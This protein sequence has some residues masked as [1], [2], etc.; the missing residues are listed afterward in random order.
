[1]GKKDAALRIAVFRD[2][3]YLA[4]LSPGWRRGICIRAFLVDRVADR[5]GNALVK[6]VGKQ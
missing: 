2:L 5:F 1:M 4:T 3:G 6:T